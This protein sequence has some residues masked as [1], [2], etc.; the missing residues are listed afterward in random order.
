MISTLL[1]FLLAI[2]LLVTVHEYGHFIVARWCGVKVLR[3]S[4]G[5][6]TVL[7]S[8]HDKHGTE[9][10]LSLI[11]LG[12]YVKML[13]E[14]VD[15]VP[16]KDRH[17]AFN[18]QSLGVRTAIVVAGPLFNF[19]FAFVALWLVS[20]I[21][22]KSLAPIIESVRPESIASRSGLVA[23]QEIIAFD[24]KKI[25][26]WHDFQY[27]I[28]PYLGTNQSVSMTVQ[29]LANHQKKTVQLPFTDLKLDDKKPDLLESIGI[30]PFIP[31]IPP[32]IGEVV[33]NS[34]AS[35][36]KIHA[37]DVILFADKTPIHDWLDLVDYVKVRPN[38]P[39]LLVFNRQDIEHS[40]SVHV[41]SQMEQGHALGFL[42]I[43]SQK[44]DWP[45]DWLR[46][47]RET[48]VRA[49]GV[50]FNQ[51]AQL[52]GTTFILMG[53][54]VSGQLPLHSLSGPVGIAKGAGASGRNGFT[55]Y[56]SFLALVSISLGVLNI[57]PIPLLD[58]GHLFY[59]L[60]ELI[61]RRPLS[62]TQQYIGNCLG[63]VFLGALMIIALSNDLFRLS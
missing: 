13:D 60:I 57:L 36:A 23:K 31:S 40:V 59:Y 47:Q 9:Y 8:W 38:Q 12:G 52:T 25:A 21:G 44:P 17:L 37:G 28:M 51:V 1:Y 42:G 62:E 58:G 22:I 2:L 11:P 7:T 54:L 14:S 16:K 33:Q 19:I 50:A 27:A 35:L 3:F 4:I 15:K 46:L 18:N 26:S 48:P 43:R 32:I 53:R 6:G 63:L 24:D 29:S 61:R 55:Y 41:A 49:I 20:V 5:F 45:A 10:A 34:P 39:V 56:L 30:V